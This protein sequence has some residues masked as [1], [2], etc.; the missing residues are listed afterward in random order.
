MKSS[1]PRSTRSRRSLA[2]WVVAYLVAGLAAVVAL[3]GGG[4]GH[5]DVPLTTWPGYLVLVPIAPI[6]LLGRLTPPIQLRD[7]IGAGAFVL[8]FG[9]V[10]LRMGSVSKRNQE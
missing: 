2:R 4:G 3:F 6:V 7:L 5:A 9:L 1:S 10:W 8:T